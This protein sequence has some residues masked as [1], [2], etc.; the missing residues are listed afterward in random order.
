MRVSVVK[1]R[2]RQLHY[3]LEQHAKRLINENIRNYFSSD[4]SW[5]D[6]TLV[7]CS[8]ISQKL[9]TLRR[10]GGSLDLKTRAHLFKAYCKPNPDYCLLVWGNYCAAQATIANRL[11]VRVKRIIKRNNAAVLCNSDFNIFNLAD[12]N[13][14]VFLSVVIEFFHYIHCIN[15]VSNHNFAL[16]AS[17]NKSMPNHSLNSFKL[18]TQQS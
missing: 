18:K 2:L 11:L 16:L 5:R 6:H 7:T 13:N 17:I 3:V 12:F 1:L 14:I 10:F 4:L 9:S 15:N 8:K